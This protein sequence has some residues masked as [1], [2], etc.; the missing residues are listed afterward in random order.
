MAARASG[1]SLDL[2][3]VL[4]T[5]AF[6]LCSA[7][8]IWVLAPRDLAMSFRGE[9]LVAASDTRDADVTEGYRAA[10]TWIERQL[11]QNRGALDS[12]SKWLTRS[13][14]LLAIEVVL[15]TMSITV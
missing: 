7:S 15:W 13:C 12:L 6:A 5:V 1:R 8:A 14:V 4:A 9:S 10:R 3:A 11:E 2:W